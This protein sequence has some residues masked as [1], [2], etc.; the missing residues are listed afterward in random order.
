MFKLG[1]T[2]KSRLEGLDGRLI[3]GVSYAINITKVDLFVV[4]GI[5]GLEQQK[6]NVASG[7]SQTMDSKHLTGDAV[8]IAAYVGREAVWEGPDMFVVGE[9]MRKGFQH[10]GTSVRWGGAWHIPD[11]T[12]YEGTLEEANEE[13]IALRKSQ[14]K[15]PFIDLP[16]WELA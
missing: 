9:A 8:D 16:H 15:K 12:K 2:S 4:E 5:R 3:R 13:Y 6:W 10:Q 14:G 1:T 7:V 11:I